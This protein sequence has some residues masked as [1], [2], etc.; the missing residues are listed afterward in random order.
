MQSFNGNDSLTTT[1]GVKNQRKIVNRSIKRSW[2]SSQSMDTG[3]DLIPSEQDIFP[4]MYLKNR[5]ARSNAGMT[6]SYSGELRSKE[7]P[8][9]RKVLIVSNQSVIDEESV[10][11]L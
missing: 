1:K 11:W 7:G 2:Q 9:S 5:I 8:S 4:L 6:P 10:S 3:L